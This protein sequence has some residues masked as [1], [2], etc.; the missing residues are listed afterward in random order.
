MVDDAR[1]QLTPDIHHHAVGR[2][3]DTRPADERGPPLDPE[4]EVADGADPA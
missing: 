3:R 4:A 2:R 1:A